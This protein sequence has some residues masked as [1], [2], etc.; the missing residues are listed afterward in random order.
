MRQHLK[1]RRGM[2]TLYDRASGTIFVHDS[3][4]LSEEEQASDAT[5]PGQSKIG[6][7]HV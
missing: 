5:L 1:M 3:F 2:L 7:A 6:R 4:G